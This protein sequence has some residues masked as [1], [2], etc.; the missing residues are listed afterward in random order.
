MTNANPSRA[1]ETDEDFVTIARVTKTQGRK[2][3]AAAL[4]LTDFPE[5]FATRKRL[6][7]LYRT[8]ERRELELEDHWFHKGGVVLKFLG[9]DSISQAETLVGCEIQIPAAE[10]APLEEDS[11]YVS[12]LIG[13]AVSDSGR[14]IGRIEDVRFGAGEAPLLVVRRNDGKEYLVPFAAAYIERMAPAEKRLEM[15]LPS[16]MLEL[17]APLTQDERERQRGRE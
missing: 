7:A 1:H 13:C 15:K 17:D 16:G 3:E 9:F 12:D 6:F 2:G 10:R 11:V 4:L 14:E 5:R 8:G